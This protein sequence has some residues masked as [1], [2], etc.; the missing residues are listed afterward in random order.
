[1]TFWCWALVIQ[2]APAIVGLEA[3]RRRLRGDA[4]TQTLVV[5]ER[6]SGFV[7]PTTGSSLI[8]SKPV[9]IGD[10]LNPVAGSARV[11]GSSPLGSE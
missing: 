10:K 6:S 8:D 7:N 9:P 11:W 3:C 4:R 5:P 1:M 2:T